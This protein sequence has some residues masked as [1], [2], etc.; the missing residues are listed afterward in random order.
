ME[1]YEKRNL[2]WQKRK[3]L[4]HIGEKVFVVVTSSFSKQ[5]N[6]ELCK[7]IG[8]YNVGYIIDILYPNDDF[9]KQSKKTYHFS[10]I[11]V[12]PKTHENDAYKTIMTEFTKN[13]IEDSNL[14]MKQLDRIN[15]SIPEKVKFT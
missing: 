4:F 14:F 7:I 3:P 9:V 12:T 2:A 1:E 5:L 11:E 15:Q 8:Y 13:P 6:I 10:W